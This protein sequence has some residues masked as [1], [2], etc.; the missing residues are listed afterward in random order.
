MKILMLTPYLP[1]PPASGGQIRT[2]N[3][4]KYLSK[5]HEITLVCLYKNNNEKKYISYLKP[6]CRAVYMCKRAEKP[7]Q[8]GNILRAIFSSY[9]FL[10]VRNYSKEAAHVL[11]D[12]LKK[13]QFDVI[14][15]ETF[16]IMPHLPETPIPF[17]LVEQTIEYEVYQHFINSLP[18]FIRPIFSLDIAKLKYW[19]R[20]YWR[21]AQLVGAVSEV[22]KKVITTLEPQIKPVV[23]PNGAGDEMFVDHL[24]P[25]DLSELKLLFVGNFFWLQNTEAADFLIKNVYPKI[26]RAFPKVSIIIAGQ[27]AKNKLAGVSTNEIQ[28]IDIAPDDLKAI[29]KLYR[30]A[31]VFIAPIFGPGGTRLKLLASMAAGLPIVSTETGITGLEVEDSKH[32]L[33]ANTPDQ[34]VQRIKEIYK[35][36][37]KYETIRKNAYELAHAKYNWQAISN[38]LEIVYKNIIRKNEVRN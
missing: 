19:E 30:E 18:F 12:L 31:T 27:N 3:L 16:Y 17:V 25:K 21:K 5:K 32:I 6:Y 37:K 9:P 36:K 34:F 20:Y 11:E 33:V 28:I 29:K 8:P 13:E 24:Y 2:L 1:Y 23:I 38:Q 4:L 10:I 35:N 7:W 14:H 15:A 26:E 22:D